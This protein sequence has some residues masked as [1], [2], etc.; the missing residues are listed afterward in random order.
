MTIIPFVFGVTLRHLRRF[1][2]IA[3]Q[4]CIGVMGIFD[5]FAFEDKKHY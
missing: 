2:P 1:S 5:N 3:E 4:Y